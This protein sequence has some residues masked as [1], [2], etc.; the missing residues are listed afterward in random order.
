MVFYLFF[1][2]K[3]P[4]EFQEVYGVFE[5]LIIYLGYSSIDDFMT[6]KVYVCCRPSLHFLWCGIVFCLP[7]TSAMTV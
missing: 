7:A 5:Y 3:C 6:F 4:H 2:S 1:N